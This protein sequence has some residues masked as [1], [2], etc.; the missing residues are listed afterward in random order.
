MAQNAARPRYFKRP[1]GFVA[2]SVTGVLV[3]MP[4]AAHIFWYFVFADGY[5]MVKSKFKDEVI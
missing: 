5:I 2:S 3:C 1:R 4:V